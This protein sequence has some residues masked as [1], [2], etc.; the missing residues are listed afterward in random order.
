LFWPA[1]AA[2]LFAAA[3]SVAAVSVAAVSAA[4]VF[5]AAVFAAAVFAAAMFAA[6]VSVAA[7]FA[8]AVSSVA[9]SAAA[10]FAAA[11]LVPV[12]GGGRGVTFGVSC[13]GS[14]P[15]L[16]VI[17]YQV[18]LGRVMAKPFSS[19]SLEFSCPGS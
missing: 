4:V 14:R 8:V 6:A 3:V 5:A 16:S 13:P 10:V 1:E 17:Q 18:L 12:E 19:P 9:V 2:A 11:S 15:K 7:V